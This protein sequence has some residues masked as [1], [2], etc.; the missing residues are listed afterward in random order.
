MRRVG[1]NLLLEKVR[2]QDI[3][4]FNCNTQPDCYLF[5]NADFGLGHVQ[6]TVSSFISS[7]DISVPTRR[8]N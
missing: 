8:D 7:I 6:Q 5:I 4:A 2:L 1:F 3:L